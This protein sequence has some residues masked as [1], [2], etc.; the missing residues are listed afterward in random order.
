MEELKEGEGLIPFI[1]ANVYK[2]EITKEEFKEFLK[3]LELGA[4]KAPMTDPF[5]YTSGASMLYAP[6]EIFIMLWNSSN[7]TVLAGI[8]THNKI[9]ERGKKL[10]LKL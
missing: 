6:D 10:G 3:M 8:D 9:L 2:G 1:K 7:T 4:N 5:A